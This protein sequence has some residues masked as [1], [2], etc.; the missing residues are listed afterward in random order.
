MSG[1][2]AFYSSMVVQSYVRRSYILTNQTTPLGVLT[3]IMPKDF[4]GSSLI[5]RFNISTLM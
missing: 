1:S 5:D 2:L 3:V 4:V